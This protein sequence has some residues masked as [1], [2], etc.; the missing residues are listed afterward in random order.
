MASIL[1]VDQIG[2]STT[3]TTALE[4]DSSGRVT[5]PARPAFM[6][7][8]SSTQ[9]ATATGWNRLNFDDEVFDI[10]GNVSSAAFTTPVAGVYQ[11][12]LSQRFDSIGSGYIVLALMDNASASEVLSDLHRASY[13]IEG[14]PANLYQSLQSSVT[15]EL[16]ANSVVAPWYYISLDTSYSL[17]TE[18]GH[19]SGFLVG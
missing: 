7:K 3:S 11:F 10:G 18:G 4:I 16:P 1:N 13:R 9:A 15:I 17:N 19:F 12:N 2:H 6:V 8:W 5:T 14:P